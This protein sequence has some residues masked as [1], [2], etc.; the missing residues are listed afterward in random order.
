MQHN[1]N[2]IRPF[3]IILREYRHLMRLTCELY[4]KKNKCN[5]WNYYDQQ[6]FPIYHFLEI[7]F[8]Q[9]DLRLICY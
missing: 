5:I 6:L 8:Y 3:L 1:L 2:S 9:G 7:K 4:V